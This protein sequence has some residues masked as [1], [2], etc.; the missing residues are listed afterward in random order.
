MDERS[1]KESLRDFQS[2]WERVA[3]SAGASP[4][5]SGEIPGE[6]ERL[7][8]FLLSASNAAALYTALA[9]RFRGAA[10]VLTRLAAQERAQLHALRLEYYLLTGE[11]FTHDAPTPAP[12]GLLGQLRRAWQA[13]GRS[14]QSY[15]RAAEVSVLGAL[16]RAHAQNERRH[17][18]LL[19]ELIARGLR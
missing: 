17:A 16:Y 15:L 5:P 19:R 7:R 3:L 8:A 11:I 10:P 9:H 2:V 4:V 14:E 18:Q 12:D 13:E 1:I 6:G